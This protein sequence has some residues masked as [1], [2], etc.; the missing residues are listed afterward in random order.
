MAM[1][2][3]TTVSR[4]VWSTIILVHLGLIF[5]AVIKLT[6]AESLNLPI[7][8]HVLILSVLSPALP[9]IAILL[10]ALASSI[11][12]RMRKDTLEIT[13]TTRDENPHRITPLARPVLAILALFD[14][15]LIASALTAINPRAVEVLL[16][17]TWQELSRSHNAVAVRTIQDALQCCGF[18]T[19]Q[20]HAYPFPDHNRNTYACVQTFKHDAPCQPKLKRET[21][22]TLGAFVAV[23]A[24]ALAV[25][26][27]LTL[28]T[29]RSAGLD[30]DGVPKWAKGKALLGPAEEQDE[31]NAGEGASN[32]QRGT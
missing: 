1:S 13:L 7:P 20:D 21:Q 5:L 2:N 12:N 4:V 30:E 6:Q 14:V 19:P 27:V 23:G 26:A 28:F 10:P 15:A 9:V 31:D 22:T 32:Q 18:T 17:T 3:I 24:F 16:K 25:K 11:H 8:L 29:T